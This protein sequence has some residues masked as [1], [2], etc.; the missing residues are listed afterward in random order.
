MFR[1]LRTGGGRIQALAGHAQLKF[2]CGM[3]GRQVW[4]V[5]MMYLA[6]QDEGSGFG[7]FACYGRATDIRFWPNRDV[8][9]TGEKVRESI[10]RAME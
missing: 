10:L 5:R 8:R 1:D 7:T 9:C 6:P 4:Q 2:S 3:V